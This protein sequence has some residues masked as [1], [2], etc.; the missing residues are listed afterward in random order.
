MAK[1]LEEMSDKELREALKAEQEKTTILQ[2]ERDTL[3]NQSRAD[4]KDEPSEEQWLAMETKFDMTREEIKKGFAMH[5]AIAAPL[6]AK[7]NEGEVSRA[8]Q[9]NVSTLLEGVTR[10]DKQFPKYSLHVKEYLADVAQAELADPEKAKKHLDRA[11]HFARGK[12]RSLGG[13][14]PGGPIQDNASP[15]KDQDSPDSYWGPVKAAFAPLTIMLKKLVPD[16]YRAAHQ[17]P[18]PSQ[19]GAIM[20][21]EEAVWK[22]QVPQRPTAVAAK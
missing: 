17:H 13:E 7:I 2:E 14:N 22:E 5:R 11:V 1:K 3:K 16:E 8:A 19:K 10:D 21:N 12:A 18:D 20:V 15:D 9:A 6:Y 4:N